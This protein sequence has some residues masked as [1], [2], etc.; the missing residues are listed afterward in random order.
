MAAAAPEEEKIGEWMSAKVASALATEDPKRMRDLVSEVEQAIEP[1]RK[2]LKAVDKVEAGK[3]YR[4]IGHEAVMRMWPLLQKCKWFCSLSDEIR[5]QL[6]TL[7]PKWHVYYDDLKSIPG[8]S[9]LDGRYDGYHFTLVMD[10]PTVAAAGI[11]WHFKHAYVRQ[12]EADNYNYDHIY[13]T[14]HKPT[15]ED[16]EVVI[17]DSEKD[18][19]TSRRGQQKQD[20]TEVLMKWLCQYAPSLRP[21]HFLA[22]ASIVLEL[23]RREVDGLFDVDDDELQAHWLDR[24]GC[25]HGYVDGAWQSMFDS[26][27]RPRFLSFDD[28][29]P[30]SVSV[31]SDESD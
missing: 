11:E 19:T 26:A 7:F 13:L 23:L 24:V 12:M 28:T 10:D 9:R 3:R 30:V 20:L 18:W 31:D 4:Q 27:Y 5:L 21:V 6:E 8:E 16:Q 15:S 22:L 29:V 14:L 17:W 2:R 25:S 1:V